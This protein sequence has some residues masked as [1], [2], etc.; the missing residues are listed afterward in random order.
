MAA[1]PSALPGK[2]AAARDAFDEC[3]ACSEIPDGL[4]LRSEL[5]K[6]EEQ[7]QGFRSAH[8][9]LLL[10][11]PP[12]GTAASTYRPTAAHTHLMARRQIPASSGAW[13][14]THAFYDS[15]TPCS[16]SFSHRERPRATKL[17]RVPTIP[18]ADGAFVDL[19]FAIAPS[20]WCDNQIQPGGKSY[21][22]PRQR[23]HNHDV[24][25]VV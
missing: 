1:F 8:C 14:G 6:C 15:R 10:L 3:H 2:G 9:L 24:S 25:K 11:C 16:R 4:D 17:E 23:K 20:Q 18:C 21:G 22:K 19:T 13:L 7:N 5:P 12:V